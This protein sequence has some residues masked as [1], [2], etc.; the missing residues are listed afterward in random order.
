M[1][2]KPE[3]RLVG[4]VQTWLEAAKASHEWT[5]DGGDYI[6]HGSTI[7]SQQKWA[8]GTEGF[9]PPR[10]PGHQRGVVVEAADEATQELR[11]KRSQGPDERFPHLFKE[12]TT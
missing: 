1:K 4:D 9:S 6:P 8:D 2:L 12:S 7:V 11:R 10:A 3:E 5:K